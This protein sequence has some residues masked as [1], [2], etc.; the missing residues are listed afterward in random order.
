MEEEMNGQGINV[1]EQSGMAAAAP[2]QAEVA[3]APAKKRI[4]V[5][6]IFL[7]VVPVAILIMLQT[8]CQIPFLGLSVY[9]LI[10]DGT[11]INDAMDM[12]DKMM[13]V[14]T[15]KYAAI[16]YIL[17]AVIGL[18][19][20]SIW[21]YKGFVK[22]NPRVDLKQVIGI[23]S[24]LAC[25][26][27]VVGLYFAINAGFILA[28]R[29]FPSVIEQYVQLIESSGITNN[30]L[31][32]VV[33]AIALGPI[34]EELCLRG[35]TFGLLEKSGIKPFFVILISGILFGVMHLNLVQGIYAAFLG[36]MLGYIR[37]KY[38]SL[39]FTVF[40]HILFNSIGTYGDELIADIG[41]KD[42]VKLILGGLAL[43]VI[44]FVIVLI[45]G[46]K[47]AFKSTDN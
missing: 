22:K 6:F 17:Y 31:I 47:K 24:I 7:S 16:T 33:Y 42:S 23:K 10:K 30:F 36:F 40:T 8:V 12:T 34:L 45:N 44:V 39:Y 5:G 19:I 32:Q 21:Y 20:F 41:L 4:R 2:V 29:F 25:F 18:I 37:Y 28:E 46:D 43:F 9:D 27:T 38:R 3:Q 11:D 14:F 13:E 35:V 1:Q 15:E 26:G